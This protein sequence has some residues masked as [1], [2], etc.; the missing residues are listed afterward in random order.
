MSPPTA[1]S[2]SKSKTPKQSFTT[3][4]GW[5][6]HF[7]GGKVCAGVLR[8]LAQLLLLLWCRVY[9]R[10]VRSGQRELG[11]S[12]L[13]GTAWLLCCALFMC[14]KQARHNQVVCV[15]AVAVYL[16][17]ISKRG[18]CCCAAATAAMHCDCVLASSRQCKHS[19]NHFWQQFCCHACI[20]CHFLFM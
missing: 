8:L 10:D 14:V 6:E 19:N 1:A 9:N 13:C 11:R 15:V 3:R 20:T 17:C 12:G 5:P 4:C 16:Q 18:C 2:C 7:R